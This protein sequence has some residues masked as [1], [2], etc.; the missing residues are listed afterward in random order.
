MQVQSANQDIF[1][2]D[3]PWYTTPFLT[4]LNHRLPSSCWSEVL[5]QRITGCVRNFALPDRYSGPRGTCSYELWYGTLQ[6]GVESDWKAKD[7]SN[8]KSV[9]DLFNQPNILPELQEN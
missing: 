6:Q 5:F 4:S 7:I 8:S 3:E 2:A 9:W 1:G